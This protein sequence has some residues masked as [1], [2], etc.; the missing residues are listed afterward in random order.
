MH[1]APPFS[2][3]CLSLTRAL[4]CAVLSYEEESFLL[5]RLISVNTCLSFFTMWCLNLF[6]HTLFSYIYWNT[7]ISIVTYQSHFDY[8]SWSYFSLFILHPHVIAIITDS[9]FIFYVSLIVTVTYTGKSSMII[10]NNP[11]NKYIKYFT[12]VLIV[13]CLLL[14]PASRWDTWC[15]CN[16][17]YNN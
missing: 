13:V 1:W 12:R 17:N 3:P 11:N 6:H 5:A 7:I 9:V 4:V 14:K 16:A 10:P 15:W 8:I 2:V